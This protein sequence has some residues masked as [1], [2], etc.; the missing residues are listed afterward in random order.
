[1]R[2]PKNKKAVRKPYNPH[3]RDRR[4]AEILIKGHAV[5]YVTGQKTCHI[6]DMN[7]LQPITARLNRATAFT[8]FAHQ[9]SYF[10]AV[11]G[12]DEKGQ[13]YLKAE[14]V[15]LIDRRKQRD[16]A[17]AFNDYHQDYVK[18][19]M[20]PNH[21]VGAGWIASAEG[22]AI[23]ERQAMDIFTVLGAW[24]EKGEQAA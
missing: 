1:M 9:W 17:D 2:K 19:S 21:L 4:K 8:E 11:L 15:S 20:N 12:I 18:R 13:Q 5:A 22:A 7:T 23:S 3:E 24:D 14:Q 6:I 16:L 10:I